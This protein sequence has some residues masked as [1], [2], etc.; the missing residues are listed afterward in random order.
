VNNRPAGLGSAE[1][2]ERFRRHGANALPDPP[3]EPGWHRILRQF[4]SPLIYI[5][6]FALALDLGIWVAAGRHDVPFEA[7]AIAAIL[8]LNAGL[9][10]WQERKAI[11]ALARLRELAAPQ[12]W[13]LRDGVLVRLASTALVP[14]DVVRLEPG[15]RIPADGDARAAEN[16]QVDESVL[17]GESLPAAKAQ[18]EEVFAGTLVVRGRAWLEVTRTGPA[19]AMGRLAVLLEG[20]KQEPTPLERRLRVFGRRVALWVLV[21]AILMA[22][23]GLWAEGVG[24][25]G[26]VLLFAVALAVAAV[27]E[28]LPAVLT[29]TLALGVERMARRKAVVRKLSAVEAL[30]SVT[31]IATDKTGTLTENRMVVH[32]VDAPD[33]DRA[34]RAMV[35]ANDADPATAAGDP[36]EAALLAHAAARGLSPESVRADCPRESSR[37]F[38]AAWRYMRVTVSEDGRR[39]SYLKG[40]PEVLLDR[41]TLDPHARAAWAERIHTA[42]GEGYRTLGLAAGPEETETDLTWLGLVLLWDPPR[43]E[44]PA[45]LREAHAAG[46]RVIMI[47]GDHPETARTVARGLGLSAEHVATGADLDQADA[48]RVRDLVRHTAVFARTAPEQKLR[49][50][51][52]LQQNGE[53]VA[54]TGDG[55]ND[56]PALKRADVGVAMG[57]RGSAVSR[58][59]ADLVLLDDNFATIVAAVEE[60]RGIY[61]NIQKFVRFLFSTNLSE[62]LVVAIGFLAAF[63]LDL[64][65]GD[66]SLLLPL[67]AAQLLWIN[68]VTD[69]APALALGLDRNPGVM[70]RPPHRPASPLLDRN[71]LRFILVAGAAKAV[72]ALMMLALLPRLGESLDAT[73]S[74]TFLFLAAGQLLLAYPARRSD[75]TP[76][77][78]R[79]LHLAIWGT[80][81]LQGAVVAVPALRPAFST[82][83]PTVLAALALGTAI[84]AAWAVAEAVSRVVWKT[85][86]RARRT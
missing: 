50:V 48:A 57:Q 12:V 72:L 18:D 26:H 82:V 67:T 27:P 83:V 35:L 10:D 84:L 60:G 34:L 16:L 54:M 43:P 7:I 28:G 59:V 19:S 9:G 21:L 38:D 31:V 74:A 30:G 11:H 58:E 75:L 39:V 69:G 47:T 4:R 56:A 52:A 42:A 20:V 33:A 13:V 55:V 70:Q 17:T 77:R 24:R 62:V 36:L 76:V 79:V 40:A 49:L 5:L 15:E 45:A 25:L 66:G 1:A 53:I 44:V 81:V 3:R 61:E 14:G 86:E 29:L 8:L 6:L 85:E 78:N 65:A 64:R 73:R 51:E 68:L 32:E 63:L 71:S 37:P 41:T 46:I 80:F 2:H 22:L 23:G